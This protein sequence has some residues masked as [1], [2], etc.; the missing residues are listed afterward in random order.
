MKTSKKIRLMI[1]VA[2]TAICLYFYIGRIVS[3]NETVKWHNSNHP[4]A[5]YYNGYQ[6]NPHEV[7]K[8]GDY[9]TVK[10]PDGTIFINKKVVQKDDCEVCRGR[11]KNSLLFLKIIWPVFNIDESCNIVDK[12]R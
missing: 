4:I 12:A 1:M 2:L 9:Y 7:A 6:I 5:V 3:F 11:E 8:T 10:N